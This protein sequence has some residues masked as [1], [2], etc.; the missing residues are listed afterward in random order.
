VPDAK[1]TLKRRDVASPG[2]VGAHPGLTNTNLQLAAPSHGRQ[3]PTAMERFYRFSWQFMPFMWQDIETGVLPALYAATTR[4]GRDQG[5]H[6]PRDDPQR[7]RNQAG[8][9]RLGDLS[10]DQTSV[11]FPT[12]N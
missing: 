9:R 10:E 8:S 12:S 4:P 7:A 2:G 6:G 3:R 1:L 11:K 5:P